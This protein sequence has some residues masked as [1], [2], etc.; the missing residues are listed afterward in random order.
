MRWLNKARQNISE[1]VSKATERTEFGPDFAKLEKDTNATK[2]VIEKLIS[3]TPSFLHPNIT[4]RTTLAL[5]TGVAKLQK[6]DVTKKYPHVAG[7]LADI[8]TVGGGEIYVRLGK[9]DSLFGQALLEVGTAFTKMC[10]AQHEYDAEVMTSFLEKLKVI[11]DKDIKEVM[12]LRKKLEGRRLDFDFKRGQLQKDPNS[13][14]V[15]HED[16]KVSEDKM[17]TTRHDYESAMV[18]L[19]DNDIEQVDILRNFV[20][21]NL[22]FYQVCIRLLED[23]HASL[24]SKIKKS[25]DKPKRSI[26][27]AV[28]D[29]DD[30]DEDEAPAPRQPAA[31][32]SAAKP[33]AAGNS[34]SRP[35]AVALFDFEKENDGELAF[36]EGDTIYLK[37]RVD[38]NWLEGEVKGQPGVVG[39]FPATYAEV[40]QDLA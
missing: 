9:E 4:A 15:S 26:K 38:E 21:A 34:S 25:G 8:L 7:E 23:A 27:A 10:E 39:V 11:D 1:K 28:Y 14:S 18:L 33:A 22:K 3:T 5:G 12:R 31:T 6:K 36:K 29:D 16:L 37:S 17:D 35:Y 20:D 24:Q 30:D 2:A 19:V 32:A 13:K 40:V